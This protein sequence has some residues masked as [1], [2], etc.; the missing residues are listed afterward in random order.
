MQASFGYS[1][2]RSTSRVFMA[3]AR[4]QNSTGRA[5]FTS[6]E[7]ATFDSI[8]RMAQG[9]L[10]KG[11]SVLNM[12]Q[13]RAS[14]PLSVAYRLKVFFNYYIRN[15]QGDSYDKVKTLVNMFDDYFKNSLQGEIE[16]RKTPKGQEKFKQAYEAGR[17]FI[18]DN[19]KALYFA[20]ASHIS[21]QRAKVFLLQKMNQIQSIGSFIRTPNGFRVTAPEGFV[22]ISSRGAVKLVDRLEFSKQNFTIAKDWVKG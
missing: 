18:K 14:D 1:N 5:T 7:M 12:L 19:E 8:I 22:A 2:S 21:L 11:S 4:F 17:K 6:S 13:E 3:S 9:S 20:I 10:S 16:K 15:H